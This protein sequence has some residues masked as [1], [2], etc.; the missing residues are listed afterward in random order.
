LALALFT[1]SIPYLPGAGW[2]G[3]VP[4]PLPIMGGLVVITTTYLAVSE[5]AK[6]WFFLR[7]SRHA[8]HRRS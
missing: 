3:F 4:L 5:A 6:R 8:T 7:E 2:L 1:I